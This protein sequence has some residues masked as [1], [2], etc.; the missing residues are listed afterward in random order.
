MNQLIILVSFVILINTSLIQEHKPDFV[1]IE[2]FRDEYHDIKNNLSLQK[3]DLKTYEYHSQA[4]GNLILSDFTLILISLNIDKLQLVVKE[5]N[6]HFT[7]DTNKSFSLKYTFKFRYKEYSGTG[8]FSLSSTSFLL[9]KN[10]IIEDGVLAINPHFELSLQFDSINYIGL[11]NIDQLVRD[12]ITDFYNKKLTTIIKDSLNEDASKFYKNFYKKEEISVE[13]YDPDRTYTLDITLDRIPTRINE[14]TAIFFRSGKLNG[15][16]SEHVLAPFIQENSYEIL[17]QNRLIYDFL[18]LKAMKYDITLNQF[19]MKEEFPFQLNIQYLGLIYP[20]IYYKYTRRSTIKVVNICKEIIPDENQHNATIQMESEVFLVSDES[21]I[22]KFTSILD[23][24][25]KDRFKDNKF[26]FY[27]DKLG[28]RSLIIQE[29]FTGV[30]ISLLRQWIDQTLSIGLKTHELRFLRNDVDLSKYLTKYKTINA[31][32]TEYGYI[33]IG[34]DSSL[35]S[36]D[37]DIIANRVFL[38]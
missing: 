23:F 7:D 21:S 5:N 24:S 29:C 6:I 22:F 25:V 38:D 2:E 37:N 17:I 28:V 19:T 30:N 18:R 13:G 12:A 10:Y 9:C 33:V 27:I 15:K 34:K 11:R 3:F 26:N 8:D 31:Q 35:N 1:L 32:M 14:S 36:I 16:E 20:N 4:L